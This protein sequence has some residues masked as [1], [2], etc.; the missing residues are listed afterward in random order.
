[1]TEELKPS[2]QP[3]KEATSEAASAVQ[4]SQAVVEE[5]KPSVSKRKKQPAPPTRLQRL[6]NFA[7]RMLVFHFHSWG[8]WSDPIETLAE[9]KKQQWRVCK[10]CNKAQN[11]TIKDPLYSRIHQ[12]DK[13]IA[14][15]RGE[16]RNTIL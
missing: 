5:K 8:K 11:R 16:K 9:D 6:K 15:S 4:Q 3:E 13:A 1:M 2:S 10:V 12:V 7:S 14:Q